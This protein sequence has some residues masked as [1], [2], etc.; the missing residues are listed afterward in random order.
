[1][2]LSSLEFADSDKPPH[3]IEQKN[4]VTLP[5]RREMNQSEEQTI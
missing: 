1:M 3:D 4:N 2:S 5:R